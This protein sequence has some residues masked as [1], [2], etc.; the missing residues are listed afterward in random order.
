[1]RPIAVALSSALPAYSSRSWRCRSAPGWR[2]WCAPRAGSRPRPAGCRSRRS[3]TTSG[4]SAC[5]RVTLASGCWPMLLRICTAVG[6]VAACAGD[7]A[8]TLSRPAVASTSAGPADAGES[9][10][11]R[12]VLGRWRGSPRGRRDDVSPAPVAAPRPI[13]RVWRCT[14]GPFD[15]PVR[16]GSG[17]VPPGLGRSV[18]PGARCDGGGRAGCRPGRGSTPAAMIQTQSRVAVLGQAVVQHQ[19]EPPGRPPRAP[20]RR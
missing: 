20:C 3:T 9:V 8:G 1:M 14:T 11:G 12:W 19:G 18:P 7:R 13:A 17:A 6:A 15:E 4:P 5:T 10:L 16:S 2:P